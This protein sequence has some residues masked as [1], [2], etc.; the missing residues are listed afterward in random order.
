M[1]E[2][3]YAG[4]GEKPADHVYMTQGSDWDEIVQGQAERSDE[5]IV[6]NFGPHHPSTH[7][8]LRMV[9][10][11]D[12]ETVL[13]V[14]PGIGFLHTGIEKNMEYRTWTQG[15]TY[16]TRANYV[17]S[18][19]NE[20][21]YCLG[22]E[23]L[24]GI[25]VPERADIM[26]V[27]VM[28]VNRLG[29]H[30]VAIGTGGLELGASS[31][32]EVCLRERE[33]CLEFLQAVTGLRMN[34]AYI[35][36]GG[37]AVDM[38]GDGV[39][40]LRALVS[41]ME[42]YLPEVAGFCNTNPVFRARMQDVATLD[43]PACMALGVT[44]PPL[45]A[46]GYPWDLRKTQPYCGYENYEFDAVTW[47]A[48]DCYGRFRVRLE[49]MNQSVRILKQVID[50]LEATHGQPVMVEDPHIKWPAQLAIGP[51]GQGNSHEHIKHIMGE[52]ME[53][54]IHHFKIVTEGF[55]V[56]AGQVYTAVE[57]P[58]GELGMHLVSDGGTRPFRAHLRDPGFNHIQA[59]P[60]LM[61]GG[62]LSDVIPA[63]A[64]IDPVMGGVD[65]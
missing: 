39:E 8:V 22:V 50:K 11:L 64:S 14:R 51:D 21:V 3:L 9:L 52:S 41:R 44:G 27:M 35:R 25:E 63:L 33:I 18:I 43:L 23:K 53:A 48:P 4:P 46:A 13:S 61:E 49:E 38:P 45:R 56:P 62:M 57:A 34:N 37:V 20:A 30:L 42:K 19:F 29:S 15:V 24:L 40:R 31:V 36:P 6:V 7:G 2:D 5:T 59:I 54:L 58:A 60:A 10:E 47:D 16:V 55:K 17:A 1:N 65:R 32:A 26:R 12:G 28:E